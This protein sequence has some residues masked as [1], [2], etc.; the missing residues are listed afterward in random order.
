MAFTW[1]VRDRLVGIANT[2]AGDA[3][4]SYDALGRRVQKTV[5]E[6][7]YYRPPHNDKPPETPP[8]MVDKRWEGLLENLAE[9]LGQW[10]S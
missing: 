10:G 3:S 5:E 9:L 6:A 1:D 2:P 7:R 4:F 8:P